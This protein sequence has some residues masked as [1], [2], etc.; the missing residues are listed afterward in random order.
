LYGFRTFIK[1]KNLK[2]I[3]SYKKKEIFYHIFKLKLKVKMKIPD[4]NIQ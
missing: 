3:I 2:T 1:I 4:N